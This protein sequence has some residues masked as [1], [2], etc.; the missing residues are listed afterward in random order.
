M[1]M[2]NPFR[3]FLLMVLALVFSFDAYSQEERYEKVRFARGAS[4]TAIKS[5]ITGYQSVNYTLDAKAGQTMTVDL[6]TNNTSNYFNLYKPGK[7]PGDQAMYIGSTKGNSFSGKL[8]ASGKYT[9]QVYLMRNAARRNETANFTLNIG[10]TGTTSVSD[11]NGTATA[12]AAA[13]LLG[14][15]ALSHHDGHYSEG[16]RYDSHQDKAEFERGYRD[17]LHNASSNNY[18]KT[19]AYRDGYKSGQ[20][21]RDLRVSHNRRNEWEKNRHAADGRIK[22]SAL[23]EAEK[24]WGLRRGSATPVSSSFNE[25]NRRYRV[26]VAAGY[27]KGVCVLDEQGN[28][29]QFIDKEN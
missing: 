13:A 26:K 24:F 8:S 21:E 25:K 5:S 28:V 22:R 17:G 7:G 14:I 4:S 27:H 16:T 20:H 11:G 19:Q 29:I 1:E 15:A 3:M 23:H 6:K 12:I 18:N 9:I 2:R 10:V